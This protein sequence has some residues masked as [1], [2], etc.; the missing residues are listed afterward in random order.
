MWKISK[1][2]L[3]GHHNFPGP[4]MHHLHRSFGHGIPSDSKALQLEGG[5]WLRQH[6]EWLGQDQKYQLAMGNPMESI[7]SVAALHIYHGFPALGRVKKSTLGFSGAFVAWL[8]E[9]L[10]LRLCRICKE[11]M[12]RLAVGG[13]LFW[14]TAP[15]FWDGWVMSATVAICALTSSALPAF[16]IIPS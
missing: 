7:D 13:S 10:D 9:A 2:Q 6:P 5:E 4:S 12:D 1:H 15:L 8:L 3:E 14:K 16:W 11:H